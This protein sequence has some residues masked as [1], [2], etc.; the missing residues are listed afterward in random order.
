LQAI[1]I[2]RTRFVRNDFKLDEAAAA[3]AVAYFDAGCPEDDSAEWGATIDFFRTHG[4]SFDW[5]AYGDP[6]TMICAT[7]SARQTARG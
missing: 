6:T 4:I 2:L 3:R 5:I 1:H 7:A